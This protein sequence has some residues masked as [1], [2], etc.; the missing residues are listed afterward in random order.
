MRELVDAYLTYLEQELEYSPHTVAAYRNDLTQFVSWLDSRKPLGGDSWRDLSEQELT[1]Y[2]LYLR[3]REYAPST[4]ARKIAAVK[5]F[6]KHL[7]EEELLDANPT[8]HLNTPRVDKDTPVALSREDME[9]L[10]EEPTRMNNTSKALRDRAILELLYGTGLRVSELV[11]VDVD[12][13]D[14]E[15]WTLRCGKGQTERTVPI[16]PRAMKALQEYLE[17]EGGRPRLLSDDEVQTLFLNMRGQ[18]LTRQGL[19]L[20]IKHYVEQ[21]AIETPVTPHT[22]RHTYAIHHYRNSSGRPEE[23]IAELQALLGHANSSTTQVYAQDS[24]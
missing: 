3:E 7:V 19:W 11:N 10:L 22:L 5:S 13:I 23:R 16:T 8:T 15:N 24:N 2:L 1:T 14:M 4:I 21:C 9:R 6:Y 20:I 12:D 17:R 18:Q